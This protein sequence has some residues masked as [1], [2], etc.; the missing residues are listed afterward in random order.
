MIDVRS[1]TIRNIY[2]GKE[3]KP[4]TL[5]FERLD[6]PVD[7]VFDNATLNEEPRLVRPLVDL[8]PSLNLDLELS[9]SSE[10][11]SG[12]SGLV[13]AMKTPKNVQGP[14]GRPVCIPPLACKFSLE[15]R[16]KLIAREAWMYDEMQTIQG[17]VVPRCYG[18]F[19]ADIPSDMEI[20]PRA[21]DDTED[22]EEVYD[23]DPLLE[24]SYRWR[25]IGTFVENPTNR[26]ILT[27]LENKRCV[28]L[29][30]LE[31]L[32]PVYLEKH[33]DEYGIIPQEIR[34]IYLLLNVII[35]LIYPIDSD[36]VYAAYDELA[37]FGINHYDINFNNICAVLTS[38]SAIPGE[39]SKRTDR[40]FACRIIDFE[41]SI[42][43]PIKPD[44]LNH[45]AENE[46]IRD[47]V[48]KVG[49]F[50]RQ[51]QL[52]LENGINL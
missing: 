50:E 21:W 36:E 47:G 23:D 4:K 27:R 8:P 11:G 18:L 29:L 6:L 15:R 41:Q 35:L 44:L 45:L 13:Y 14:D 42:R 10:L 26:E 12:Y 31:R 17:V 40:T 19:V 7:F 16:N 38:P 30:L 28:T 3:N 22:R 49:F 2:E 32:G 9:R 39:K 43:G 48:F 46:L 24:E 52:A 33:Q 1:I 51:R 37:H 20:I 34:C 5:R 25:G